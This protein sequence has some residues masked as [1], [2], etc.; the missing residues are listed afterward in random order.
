MDMYRLDNE[1]R[2]E[3]YT[4]GISLASQYYTVETRVKPGNYSYPI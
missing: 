4:I 3:K 1:L 2:V